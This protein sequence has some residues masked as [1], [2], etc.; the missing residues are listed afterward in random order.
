MA[1]LARYAVRSLPKLLP[2]RSPTPG[3]RLAYKLPYPRKYRLNLSPIPS[4]IFGL[5][6]TA[7]AFT[8]ARRIDRTHN[9]LKIP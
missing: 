2:F 1:V 5:C 3:N 9:G 8:H 4:G 7:R 6:A